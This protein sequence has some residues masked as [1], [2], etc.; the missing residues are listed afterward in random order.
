[1]SR[2]DE[3]T[4]RSGESDRWDDYR[5]ELPIVG[6]SWVARRQTVRQCRRRKLLRLLRWALWIAVVFLLLWFTRRI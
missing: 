5:N 4:C 3:Y 6:Y 2:K 1:M